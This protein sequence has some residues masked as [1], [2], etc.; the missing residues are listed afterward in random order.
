MP[1]SRIFRAVVLAAAISVLTL[2]SFVQA[3]GAPAIRAV[4]LVAHR[5]VYEITLNQSREGVG[6]TAARGLMAY[7]FSDA[8][9]SWI[10]NNRIVMDVLFG[11]ET[12]VRTDWTFNSWESKD[13]RE[14]GYKLVHKR[15]GHLAEELMG[16]ANLDAKGG[17]A[18]FTGETART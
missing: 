3:A 15:N 18:E 16:K 7:S 1:I 2:P 13:S 12:P 10:V 11:E 4:D 8:C 5:A 17:T 14:Y 6:P 9:E